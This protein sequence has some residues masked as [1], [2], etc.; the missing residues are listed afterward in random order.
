[1][2]YNL[3]DFGRFVAGLKIPDGSPLE[4]QPFQRQLLPD[5]FA[6]TREL[7]ILV[8][9]KTGRPR[10]SPRWPSSTSAS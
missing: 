2:K 3:A 7:V 9:K 5:H 4:L 8:P 1:M 10:C 6:G